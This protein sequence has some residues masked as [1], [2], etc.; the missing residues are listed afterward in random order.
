MKAFQERLKEYV[1][2]RNK[3]ETTVPQLTETSD[4]AKISARERALGEALIKARG[5]AQPGE[6]FIKEIQPVFGRSSKPTSPNAHPPSGKRSS[7][8]CPKV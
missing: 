8:S 2:F 7:W 3:V 5:N 1:A 4:P 6:Y